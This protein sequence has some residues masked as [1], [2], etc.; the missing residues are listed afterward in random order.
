[1]AKLKSVLVVVL[2]MVLTLAWIPVSESLKKPV[3][4]ARKEDQNR[5]VGEPE[6]RC[7]EPER[8]ALLKFKQHLH[9]I[10]VG[11]LSSW[12]N[13][14]TDCCDWYGVQ[15]SNESGHVTVLDLSPST[16]SFLPGT[17]YNKGDDR[18][19]RGNITS[20]LLELKF[21]TYLDLSIVDFTGNQ[22]PSFIGALTQLRYLNLSYTEMSG[23]IPPQFANL[24]SLQVLDLGYNYGL[25]MTNMEWVSHLSSLTILDL[26]RTNMSKATDWVQTVTKLPYLT[27]LVLSMCELP[28]ITI[29]SSIS[30]VNTS[31][32][33]AILDLSHNELTNSVYQLIFKFSRSLVHLN[34]WDNQVTGS[35]PE[36]FLNTSAIEYLELGVNELEGFIPEALGNMSTLTYLGLSLN[37]FSGS[38]PEALGNLTNLTYIDIGSNNLEG[39]FPKSLW[40][41]CKLRTSSARKTIFVE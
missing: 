39:E 7:I 10:K 6:T 3:A 18:F 11:F 32:S 16:N 33:L 26:T 23:E 17:C 8:Q 21:L 12:E 41:L 19:L 9:Q 40:N 34:L 29:P 38:I 35:I 28:N 4:L 31:K 14:N 22:L 2:V 13:E 5:S 37:K 27:N 25:T 1:M 20:W 36:A 15:C 24:S 30:L